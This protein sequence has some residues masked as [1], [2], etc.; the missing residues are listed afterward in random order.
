VTRLK[1]AKQEF[2]LLL[3]PL[4]P[5][6]PWH[7][8][9]H[10]YSR[11]EMLLV[12]S[13][14]EKNPTSSPP[15]SPSNLSAPH[16]YDFPIYGPPISDENEHR[17]ATGIFESERP[18]N[19]VRRRYNFVHVSQRSVSSLSYPIL[20]VRFSI[21]SPSSVSLSSESFR[22][23]ICPCAQQKDF[24]LHHAVTLTVSRWQQEF[25]PAQMK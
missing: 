3:S 20:L 6:R 18:L 7:S 19:G 25:L 16:Q 22:L 9:P 15:L 4:T 10:N 5:H 1:K 13:W 8:K 11:D 14:K 17:E 2:F 21:V 24:R 12:G 23:R